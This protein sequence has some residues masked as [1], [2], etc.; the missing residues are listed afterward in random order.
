MHSQLD[1]RQTSIK[2]E[3]PSK[4][5]SSRQS[6]HGAC[7]LASDDVNM[8]RKSQFRKLFYLSTAIT[9]ADHPRRR[10]CTY[11]YI[12][13]Y[14][15][16]CVCVCVYVCIGVHNVIT[17]SPCWRTDAFGSVR[18]L[19]CVPYPTTRCAC[20]VGSPAYTRRRR[21]RAYGASRLS[22]IGQSARVRRTTTATSSKSSII[23]KQN[24]QEVAGLT[25]PR[26]STRRRCAPL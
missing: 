7:C 21:H 11:I 26:D 5:A 4:R 1:R 12:Y 24:G 16:V 8:Q 9:V 3:T 14:I 20:A 10:I 2:P 17:H 15:C 18:L 23:G 19:S 25:A 22:I 6:L 13:I